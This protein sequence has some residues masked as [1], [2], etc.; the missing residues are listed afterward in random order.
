MERSESDFGA[1]AVWTAKESIPR[2]NSQQVLRIVA[3]RWRTGVTSP[4][5]QRC[6]R[7]VVQR[8]VR[9]ATACDWLVA[10]ARRGAATW[11]RCR[12][13][14]VPHGIAPAIGRTDFSECQNDPGGCR[15]ISVPSAI[16]SYRFSRRTISQR[17]ESRP[18]IAGRLAATLAKMARQLSSDVQGCWVKTASLVLPTNTWNCQREG[19]TSITSTHRYSAACAD[20]WHR[21]FPSPTHQRRTADILPI[22][23]AAPTGGGSHQLRLPVGHLGAAMTH[24]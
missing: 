5:S 10:L 2:E 11:Q 23:P 15:R 12:S 17:G 14:R 8:A 4:A 21:R 6:S 19:A 9:I 20:A 24:C 3:G 22:K 18:S 13:A 7:P 1:G 16:Q